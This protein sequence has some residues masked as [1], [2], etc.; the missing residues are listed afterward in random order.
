MLFGY[1]QN[2]KFYSGLLQKFKAERMGKGCITVPLEYSKD[3][4][5]LFRKYKISVKIK[6]V[7]EY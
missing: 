4:L 7:L 6:K 1:T 3:I 5:K 2:K